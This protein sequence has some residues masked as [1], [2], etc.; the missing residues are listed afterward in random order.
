METLRS[1]A[2]K[3]VTVIE[4]RLLQLE[5]EKQILLEELHGLRDTSVGTDQV[6]WIIC[7][8]IHS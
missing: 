6:Y 8:T 1:Q 3:R 4:D 2:G 7:T 5:Q